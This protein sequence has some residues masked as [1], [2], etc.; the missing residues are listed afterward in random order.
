MF[1]VILSP[2]L[3]RIDRVSKLMV[4]D[5]L[6]TEVTVHVTGADGVLRDFMMGD[7]GGR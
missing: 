6:S 1:K 3:T 5:R 7:R 2:P 4:V